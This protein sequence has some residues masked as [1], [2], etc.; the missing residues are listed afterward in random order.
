MAKASL[1]IAEDIDLRRHLPDDLDTTAPTLFAYRNEMFHGGLEWP[2]EDR[3]KFGNWVHSDG[4]T[5]CF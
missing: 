1:Q 4:W 3:T 5:D 2:E